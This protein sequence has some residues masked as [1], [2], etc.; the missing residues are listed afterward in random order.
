[1]NII[2]DIAGRFDELMLLIEKMPK[3]EDIILLGDLNDRG[4]DS[5]KVIQWAIDNKIRC[6]KSNHG[7]MLINAYNAYHGTDYHTCGEDRSD[8][9]LFEINGGYS[10]LFSYGGFDNIPKEHIE[11]LVNLPWYIETDELFLS[12]G[13]WRE[14]LTLE[15]AT[16]E[17]D[18]GKS[19]LW[20]RRKP[21]KRNKFQIHGHNTY[22]EWYSDKYE[23]D[24]DGKVKDNTFGL[25]IDNSGNNQLCGINWPSKH[26]YIQEYL[27]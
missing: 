15:Q 26:I 25:C 27:D 23:L 6:V 3:G 10:T 13:P 16:D 5:N 24:T 1:M 4:K 18:I 22:I 2:G 12:H 8:S 17:S 9:Y 11:W 7:S 14:G 21:E 19:L 20:N